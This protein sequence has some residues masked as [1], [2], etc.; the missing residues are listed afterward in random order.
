MSVGAVQNVLLCVPVSSDQSSALDQ[1]VCPPSSTQY[2][3]VQA[4]QA[5]VVDPASAG[6]LDGLALPFDYSAAAGFF[7]LAFTMIVGI[8]MVSASAGSILAL[9]KRG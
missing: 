6:F 8:W 7:A 5:Y 3:H 1:Q 2:F 9:I 4:Q